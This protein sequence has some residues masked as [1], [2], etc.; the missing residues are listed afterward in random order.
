MAAGRS[1]SVKPADEYPIHL[2]GLCFGSVLVL[3][4]DEL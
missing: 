4:E 2:Y 3:W 1:G